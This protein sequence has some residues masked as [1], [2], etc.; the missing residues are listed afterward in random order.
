MKK[1]TMM[2]LA[3]FLLI[4]VLITTST[5][6]GTYAKYVT[7]DSASDTA[8]VAKWGVTVLASGSL[9]G[10]N[11]VP[12]SATGNKDAISATIQHSVDVDV[13]G[14]SDIVAPGTKNENGLVLAIKGDPEVA[15]SIAYATEGTNSDIWLS[16]GTYAVMV[17]T[18]KV[19]E[20][21]C[22]GYYYKNDAEQ[23]VAA[24]VDTEFGDVDQ[25]YEKHDDATVAEN[26]DG[27]G[28]YYPINWTVTKEGTTG[29]LEATQYRT[30]EDV[31]TALS[32]EFATTTTVAANTAIDDKYRLTWIWEF[33]QGED[34][35][36]TILGNLIGNDNST[37]Y[38]VV[39][40]S[41]G[42]Y[43]DIEATDYSLNVAFGAKITVTQVN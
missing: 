14:S 4:A 29:T 2:R 15:Y 7:S 25:W 37:S 42:N 18:D 3:S 39:K 21:N 17:K 33:D 35:A 5:I 22:V 34:D 1:N 16:A 9:F 31:A 19:T 8:R 20:D 11:Y 12:N 24:T 30:I 23:Y 38:Q 36:D 13:P 26:K 32:D 43:V 40:L 27:A 6:S 41:G 28:K 10:E